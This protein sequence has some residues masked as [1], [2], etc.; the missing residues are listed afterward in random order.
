MAA[1]GAPAPTLM[2]VSR[3]G[4]WSQMPGDDGKDFGPVYPREGEQ[5]PGPGYWWNDWIVSCHYQGKDYRAQQVGLEKNGAG[6]TPERI[7]GIFCRLEKHVLGQIEMD[8]YRDRA[9]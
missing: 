8:G 3:R 4:W 2:R 9:R 5:P 1:T 7:E 6:Y